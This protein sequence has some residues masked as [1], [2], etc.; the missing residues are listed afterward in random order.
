MRRSMSQILQKPP[1]RLPQHGS[2]H[3][4]VEMQLLLLDY[5][6]RSAVGS[7]R[8]GTEA[9]HYAR[10]DSGWVAEELYIASFVR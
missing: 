9:L 8:P 6:G 4:P 2:W 3:Q 1:P 10:G 7:S 5:K